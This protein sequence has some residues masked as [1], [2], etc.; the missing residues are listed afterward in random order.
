MATDLLIL[1]AWVDCGKEYC[2]SGHCHTDL[3]NGMPAKPLFSPPP[4]WLHITGVIAFVLIKLCEELYSVKASRLTEVSFLLQRD[5]HLG[6]DYYSQTL[7]QTLTLSIWPLFV[8]LADPS[9]YFFPLWLTTAAFF[10]TPG[11][12]SLERCS[13]GG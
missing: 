2:F 7:P 5:Q 11:G 13:G 12:V 3:P 6:L 1:C 9:P 4:C 10:F 8:A